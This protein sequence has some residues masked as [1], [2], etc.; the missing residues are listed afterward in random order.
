VES[1]VCDDKQKRHA[2]QPEDS[3]VGWP[4]ATLPPQPVQSGEVQEDGETAEETPERVR[5]PAGE[6]FGN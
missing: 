5:F 6:G 2:Q 4:E 3:P 1:T